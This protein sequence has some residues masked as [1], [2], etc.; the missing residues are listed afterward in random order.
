[1]SKL[2]RKFVENC[3]SCKIRKGPSGAK[4]VSLQPLDGKANGQVKRNMKVIKDN[5]SVNDLN[6]PWHNAFQ[7]LRLAVNCTVSKST[8]KSPLELLLDKESSSIQLLQID[9][10]E[11]IE[12]VA[13]VM[14]F[15]KKRMNDQSY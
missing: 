6:K 3:V 2:V 12:D 13:F 15:C 14:A 5:M 10:D 9:D 11:V 7:D 1:M 4:Q 8:G